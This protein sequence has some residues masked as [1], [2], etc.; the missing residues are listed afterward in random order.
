[1]IIRNLLQKIYRRSFRFFSGYNL[2]RFNFI[3]NIDKFIRLH[4][5]STFAKVNQ[6]KMFLDSKDS[7]NLSL[8]GTY[9]PLETK[10][11]KKEIEQGN[12]VLDIGANI[13]Y[14]TLIFAKLVGENGKVYA[15]EPDP[16]NYSL[17]KKNIKINGY[18][19]VV[20]LQ[21]AV[22]NKT[23]KINLYLSDDNNGD[24]RIYNSHDKRHSLKIE[25]VRL[26]DYF[27][28]YQGK[29]D[30]IKMDIQ[31]AECI[32]VHGMPLLLKKNKNIKLITEFWPFAIKK[33]G[34][35]HKK[36]LGLLQKYGFKLYLI[37]ELTKKI[38]PT[39]IDYLLKRYT[40]KNKNFTNLL[41]IK[42]EM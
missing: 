1:M 21:K 12:I 35:D 22:S 37:D 41:C 42:T 6:H 39:N 4:L 3:I 25:V 13:G 27:K 18:K 33:C 5:K 29:I 40:P 32:A 11:V 9:E 26:D 15:F 7:L 30:F 16:T 20:L 17:L 36:Y 23:G 2:G 31:G 19:N 34:N 14:Y 10:I 8:F 28:D 24:H 38:Q